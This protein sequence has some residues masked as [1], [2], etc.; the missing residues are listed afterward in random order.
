MR[1]ESV[2]VR[3]R[4][5]NFVTSIT[6]QLGETSLSGIGPENT[7]I[8]FDALMQVPIPRTT[9]ILIISKIFGEIIFVNKSKKIIIGLFN[10]DLMFEIESHPL[11]T[12]FEL[13]IPISFALI[14]KIQQYRKDKLYLDVK[15]RLGYFLW[16]NVK[17]NF[18]A[19]ITRSRNYKMIIPQS[20]WIDCL[21]Q[22]GY[23]RFRMLEL[24]I[25]DI[26]KE[27]KFDN[28]IQNLLLAND[29]FLNGDYKRAIEQCRFV[30]ED[31]PK[32]KQYKF[33]QDKRD[34]YNNRVSI[35]C[36]KFI[37][38]KI[39][40]EKVNFLKEQLSSLWRF[41]SKFHHTK[42][43]DVT[44]TITA[45]RADAEFAINNASGI[46][47]YLGKIFSSK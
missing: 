34:T 9:T 3:D 29:Y 25:P 7:Q 42:K 26:V 19:G 41:T 10:K 38:P 39:A 22:M 47:A 40:D 6:I 21:N 44:K 30:I 15:F 1:Q 18:Y 35:F 43:I 46:V 37:A 12:N 45:N 13:K 36:E 5:Q 28:M 16:D 4:N 8:K 11:D 32:L 14:E 24:R 27:E 31:I 20:T 23:N 2:E 33:P 17:K